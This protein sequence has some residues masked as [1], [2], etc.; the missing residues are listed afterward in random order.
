[1]MS[2]VIR[3]W[4]ATA[5]CL[6]LAGVGHAQGTDNAEYALGAGDVI[7]VT[8]F[9]SP[10][11]SLETRISE[12]GLVTYPLIGQVRLGGLPISQA[13]K[14]LADKLRQGNFLKQPQVSI[15][16]MTVRGN[17]ASLLGQVAR[18]G[19]YPLEQTNTR[20]SDLLA[21]AG[22]I[23]PGGSDVITVVGTRAGKPYR[24]QL[25]LPAIF[26]A[27]A[28]GAG[29]ITIQN[30]DVVYVDRVPTVY[31]YG[32]VQRPGAIRL[33]RGMTVMQALATGGGLNQRG[34]EKGLRIHRRG[35]DGKVQVS[36]PAMDDSLRDGDVVYVRESLF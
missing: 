16:L 9:Q 30:G 22:G 2:K 34:T 11:L 19:R 35:T 7:K 6:V 36:Q 33:E 1:M 17:Q 8:V 4:L 21:V 5:L 31:I 15:L 23:A 26:S 25:D 20:L 29:D 32:E 10:D 24:A 14:L 28:Q 13:E 3:N 12:T 27:N 18:P